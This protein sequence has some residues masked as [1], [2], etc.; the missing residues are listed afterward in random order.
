MKPFGASRKESI[1][2]KILVRQAFTR[3]IQSPT[4]S[5]FPFHPDIFLQTFPQLVPIETHL[6]SSH[7]H[8]YPDTSWV[9]Q[10]LDK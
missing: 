1:Y 6:D 2:K 7:P 8:A 4:E 5:R 9:A 10:Q 3:V